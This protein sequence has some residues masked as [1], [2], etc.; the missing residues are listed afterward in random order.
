M[1]IQLIH[2][3]DDPA[4]DL[5]GEDFIGVVEIVLLV[6]GILL[7]IIAASIFLVIFLRMKKDQ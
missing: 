5:A 2:I 4:L 7:T 3:D 1:N 6:A